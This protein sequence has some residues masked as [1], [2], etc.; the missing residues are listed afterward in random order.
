VAL[1]WLLGLIHLARGD[2]TRALEE[3]ELELSLESA[4]HLYA[5]ECCANTWYAIGALRLRQ[6]R[7][8]D[9]SA[10]FERALERMTTH[11]MARVGLVAAAAPDQGSGVRLAADPRTE[12]PD[13]LSTEAAMVRAA[14]LVVTGDH[15]D[16]ARL[17]DE[18]LA[19]AAPG[20]A[21]WLLPI[22]PLLH[23]T[24]HPDV[25]ACPLAHLRNRAA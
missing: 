24:S 6:R 10:A 25:W 2:E 7:P 16:A 20:N 23:V 22:E 1:H 15:V 9:A 12:E 3:F 19:R 11:P 14:Q 21:G 8:A 17:I 13:R 4:G 18:A 5:R